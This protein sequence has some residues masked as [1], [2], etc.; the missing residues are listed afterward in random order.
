MTQTQTKP[1]PVAGERYQNRRTG[2]TYVVNLVVTDNLQV[3]SE[4]KNMLHWLSVKGFL[5]DYD[6]LPEVTA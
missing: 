3:L 1:N 5:R 6:R 2:R 4:D